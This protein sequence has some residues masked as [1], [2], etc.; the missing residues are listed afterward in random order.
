[1]KVDFNII[2]AKVYPSPV[3]TIRVADTGNKYGGAHHYIINPMGRYSQ[4]RKCPEYLTDYGEIVFVKKD[5]V[6]GEFTPGYQTEQL[7]LVLLD[8]H[9]KLSKVFPSD[10]DDEF[11]AHLNGALGALESRVRDRESRGV[12]GQLKK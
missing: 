4:E 7:L 12:M 5:E 6:T 3:N 9:E 11:I 8:R 2:E 10:T 1:M